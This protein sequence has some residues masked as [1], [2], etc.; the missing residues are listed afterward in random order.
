MFTHVRLMLSSNSLL[1]FEPT[2]LDLGSTLVLTRSGK[3]IGEA[4][5]RQ[6]G[7]LAKDFLAR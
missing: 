6:S 5:R 1:E 4:G 7:S 3:R 2:N